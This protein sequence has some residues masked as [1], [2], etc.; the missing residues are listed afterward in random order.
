MP[1]EIEGLVRQSTASL[2]R[3]GNFTGACLMHDTPK[4]IRPTGPA[5]A[6]NIAVF[7]YGQSLWKRLD[8]VPVW[9]PTVFDPEISSTR[10]QNHELGPD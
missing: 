9:L 8:A 7:P 5:A 6:A 4:V 2:V 3:G 10:R 1:T